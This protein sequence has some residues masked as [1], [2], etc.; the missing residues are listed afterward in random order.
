MMDCDPPRGKS[1]WQF[2]WYHS[3]NMK[4]TSAAMVPFAGSPAQH[5]ADSEVYQAGKHTYD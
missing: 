1:S 2:G 3:L 4:A 5:A